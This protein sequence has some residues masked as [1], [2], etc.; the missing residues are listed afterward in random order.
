MSQD[1]ASEALDLEEM[2]DFSK[3][4]YQTEAARTKSV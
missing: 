2:S 4:V 3:A 1:V